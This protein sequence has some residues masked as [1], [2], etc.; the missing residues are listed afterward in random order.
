[1]LNE[2]T[3][4]AADCRGVA[5]LDAALAAAALDAQW[6][7]EFFTRSYLELLA[8]LPARAPAVAVPY[9][10]GTLLATR[11]GRL[12]GVDLALIENYY[13]GLDWKI[14]EE[15]YDRLAEKL[16]LLIV[17]HGHWDHCWIELIELLLS[18]GKP[19][20]AVAGMQT[21]QPKKV[22]PGCRFIR[23]GEQFP[24]EGAQLAFAF[25]PHAYDNGRHIPLM[26]TRIRDGQVSV[27]HTSDADTTTGEGWSRLDDEAPDVALF[28]LGGVSPLVAD[29]EE[30]VRTIARLRP[31]QLILPMHLNELGH[32][33]TDACRPYGL[34]CEWLDRYAGSG[35][36]GQRRYAVL[37]GSRFIRL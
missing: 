37:F 13:S 18:R 1:M 29:D 19:V 15:L 11:S 16:D 14:P 20:F 3:G 24:W 21:D 23:D 2:L 5:E 28:K 27:L 33:G 30:M 8:E 10:C 9:N 35:A 12:L 26:T 7:Q 22:P 25:A 36:L 6:V 34:A 32:R 4:T 17:S 31:R